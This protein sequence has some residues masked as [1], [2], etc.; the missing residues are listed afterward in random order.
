MKI[1]HVQKIKGVA[2]SEKYLMALLPELV[3]KGIQVEL[4]CICSLQEKQQLHS[5]FNHFISQNIA[6]HVIEI[7]RFSIVKVVRNLKKIVG[8]NKF[9][10]VNSHLIH[11]EFYCALLKLIG[12]K[13]KLVSTK[14]GYSESFTSKGYFN[15]NVPK[16]LYYF[17]TKFNE[18]F[19][20]K[21]IAVSKA[22]KKLYYNNRLTSSENIE[23][24]YHG[25]D[26]AKISENEIQ[27]SSNYQLAIVGR[28]IPLKGHKYAL[29]ALSILINR[30]KNVRLT[31]VGSGSH[32]T[33]LRDLAKELNIADQVKFVGFQSNPRVWMANANVVLVPSISEGFGL[34]I[35]EAFSVKK[36]VIA[37]DVPACNEIV[38]EFNGFLIPPFDCEIFAQKIELLLTQPKLVHNKGEVALNDQ[39]IKFNLSTM[40]NKHCQF[41]AN[42]VA[43]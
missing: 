4:V 41:Y 25:Y 8:Q 40:I 30:V 43:D 18:K 33:V 24:I 29:K 34:T 14:H 42:C 6:V 9:D 31:I 16:D 7:T 12:V 17:I 35:I 2:G 37:F 27:T 21:S 36:P 23:V 26:Y 13:F 1:L 32:E 5:F 20:Y 22:L 19:I 15:V 11:A 38:N 28:L 10:I 39:L 3:K